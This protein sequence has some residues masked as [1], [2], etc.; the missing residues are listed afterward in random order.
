MKEGDM[1][2]E[3]TRERRGRRLREQILETAREIVLESGVDGLSLREVARRLDYSAGALYTYFADKDALLDALTAGVFEE[4]GRYFER[5]PADLPPAERLARLGRAYLDFAGENP[6]QYLLVFTRI[7]A[8]VTTR[9]DELEAAPYPWSIVVQT[10][11]AGV[12]AGDLATAEGYGGR[13]I[14]FH[15]FALHHGLAMLRLTR[16]RALPPQVFG[17]ISDAV[18]DAFAR[19][20][21]S[22]D[23]KER[24]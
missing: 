7:A 20:L 13:E 8:P 9:F 10:C 12:V 1:E 16:M 19:G 15:F 22:G 11:H 21:V 14:F 23:P 2:E 5:V 24:S 3:S 18:R 17:P 6:E 4:L